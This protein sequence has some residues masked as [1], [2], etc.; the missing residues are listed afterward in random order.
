MGRTEIIPFEPDAVNAA[1]GK[2]KYPLSIYFPK[3]I[4]KASRLLGV[5]YQLTDTWETEI[6]NDH[7]HK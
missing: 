4:R 1:V 6:Y 7:H 2:S 3:F 5:G